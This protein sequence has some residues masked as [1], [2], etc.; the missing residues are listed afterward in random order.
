[1]LEPRSWARLGPRACHNTHGNRLHHHGWHCLG[2]GRHDLDEPSG[3]E[4]L[5]A[6]VGGA[7]GEEEA[8]ARCRAK[9]RDALLNLG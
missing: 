8:V 2:P 1:M 6:V 9:L 7:W 3:V 4:V 5:R